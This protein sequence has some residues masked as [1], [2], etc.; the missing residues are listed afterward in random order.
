[1]II[2]AQPR[3]NRRRESKYRGGMNAMLGIRLERA[4]VTTHHKL[5]CGSDLFAFAR[6]NDVTSA[7]ARQHCAGHEHG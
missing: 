2:A 6:R 5:E 7:F 3:L 4:F 1:M